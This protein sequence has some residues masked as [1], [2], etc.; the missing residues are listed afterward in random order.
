VI[1]PSMAAKSLAN[2]SVEADR[3]NIPAP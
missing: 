1:E 3:G 2:K